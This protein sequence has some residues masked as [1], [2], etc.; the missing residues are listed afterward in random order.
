M[1]PGDVWVSILWLV[2]QIRIYLLGKI[3]I[4]L[5]SLHVALFVSCS[6]I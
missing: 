3:D 1:V 4:I 5:Y 2:P 6:G